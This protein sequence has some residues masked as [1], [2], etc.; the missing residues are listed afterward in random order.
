[1]VRSGFVAIARQAWRQYDRCQHVHHRTR[2]ASGRIFCWKWYP[3]FTASGGARR[4][5]QTPRREQ[6]DR[7]CRTEPAPAR[8]RLF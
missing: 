4:Y 8:L 2:R 6:L 1:M 5:Q 7:R 3:E